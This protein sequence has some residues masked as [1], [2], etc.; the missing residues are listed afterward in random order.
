M[1][2]AGILAK[3]SAG[4]R[5]SG[6]KGPEVATCPLTFKGR[7]EVSRG[8]RVERSRSHGN[9]SVAQ[10]SAGNLAEQLGGRTRLAGWWTGSRHRGMSTVPGTQKSLSKIG[11]REEGGGEGRKRLS[12]VRNVSGSSQKKRHLSCPRGKRG[13]PALKAPKLME[14]AQPCPEGTGSDGRGTPPAA[15]L[16]PA[17]LAECVP[18]DVPGSESL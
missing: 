11:R 5:K 15:S 9:K 17:L 13:S 14:E 2:H 12:L 10:S 18:G 4:G 6:C 16:P 8:R 3:C 7:A 1:N